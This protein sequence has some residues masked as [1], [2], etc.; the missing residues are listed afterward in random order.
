MYPTDRRDPNEQYVHRHRATYPPI[1]HPSIPGHYSS[2]SNWKNAHYEGQGLENSR[3]EETRKMNS[4]DI[5]SRGE[6]LEVPPVTKM[7]NPS[8]QEPEQTIVKSAS[9]TTTSEPVTQIVTVNGKE[10][11][12]TPG[13]TMKAA[14]LL[15]E[16]FQQ[17][18]K[19]PVTMCFERFLGAGK[20]FARAS[21]F[22][23]TSSNSP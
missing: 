12:A 18:L 2:V 13:S 17:S 1:M 19:S 3:Y 8:N 22:P 15:E 16:K 14:A 23:A 5:P 11:R 4:V 7:E 20:Y 9:R 21:F 6:D 10:E